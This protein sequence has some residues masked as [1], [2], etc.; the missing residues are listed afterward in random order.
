[1]IDINKKYK[2]R[3]GL[4]VRILCTDR[5][6]EPYTVV[7]LVSYSETVEKLTMHTKDGQYFRYGSGDELDLVEVRPLAVGDLVMCWNG[8]SHPQHAC[9]RKFAKI[10]KE[11]RPI[12]FSAN[13]LFNDWD[14]CMLVEEYVREYM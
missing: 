12:T 1:M 8:K 3:S 7:A 10:S 4:P 11:G 14:N 2:T 9:L 13:G 6:S 5:K